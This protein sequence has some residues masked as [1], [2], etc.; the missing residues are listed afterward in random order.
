MK[1]D[2]ETIG[3]G[4]QRTTVWLCL[5]LFAVAFFGTACKTT[6]S[7]RKQVDDA[8]ITVRVKQKLATDLNLSSVTNIDVNT[9]NGVVTLAGQ[10]E[11]E[12]IRRQAVELT[13]SLE[14]VVGVND[15]LQVEPA[16]LR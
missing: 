12:Q 13:A 4:M 5:T 9:T 16:A 10:V 7:P 11:S 8:A 2:L 14:G 15:N 1:T 3:H 6:Q